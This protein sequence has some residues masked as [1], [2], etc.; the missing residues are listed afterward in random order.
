MLNILLCKTAPYQRV[1]D[2][3]E[4][5]QNSKELLVFFK[6]SRLV[7]IKFDNQKLTKLDLN[8]PKELTESILAKIQEVYC[9]RSE[10]IFSVYLLKDNSMKR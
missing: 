4:K 1:K 3:L 8:L 6:E 10:D 9:H 2:S 7:Y 5:T